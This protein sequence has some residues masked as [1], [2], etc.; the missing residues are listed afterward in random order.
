LVLSGVEISAGPAS[1]RDMLRGS[2]RKDYIPDRRTCL[3]TV[4]RVG[5]EFDWGLS[6]PPV[7][8]E[9]QISTSYPKV[10]W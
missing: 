4:W 10:W 9:M 6:M 8:L 5:I 3:S 2:I 1:H 7:S